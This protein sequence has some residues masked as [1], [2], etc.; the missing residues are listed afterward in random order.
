MERFPDD[1]PVQALLNR[2]A[3]LRHDPPPDGWDGVFIA[4]DK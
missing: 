1:G 2:I 3:H 4:K